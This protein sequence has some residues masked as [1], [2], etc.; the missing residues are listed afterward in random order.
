LALAQE[1]GDMLAADRPFDR[2]AY[3][4]AL[5]RLPELPEPSEPV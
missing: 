2:D 4:Q 1:I 3:E 5:R